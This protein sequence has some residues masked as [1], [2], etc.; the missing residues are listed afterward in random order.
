MALRPRDGWG[1][2]GIP[3]IKLKHGLSFRAQ[4]KKIFIL[5]HYIKL[6]FNVSI[7]NARML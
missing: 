5:A 7:R 3:T 2:N 1:T 6:N 4:L